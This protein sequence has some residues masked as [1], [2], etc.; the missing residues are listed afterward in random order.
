MVTGGGG[1]IFLFL[2]LRETESEARARLADDSWSFV[3]PMVKDSVWWDM[4]LI[5]S[6]L[7]CELRGC[8]CIEL[9]FMILEVSWLSRL[10]R[11]MMMEV[12]GAGVGCWVGWLVASSNWCGIVVG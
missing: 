5:S 7:V 4:A 9:R 2:G 3:V 10:G 12:S 6:S 11:G 1:G 8:A